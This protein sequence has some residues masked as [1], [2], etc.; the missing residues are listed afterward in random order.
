MRL[1][2]IPMFALLVASCAGGPEADP[3]TED[4]GTTEEGI[5]CSA[6]YSQCVANAWAMY[7]LRLQ[8]CHPTPYQED[9]DCE[10]RATNACDDAL[11][12][13]GSDW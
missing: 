8:V 5:W 3:S 13:C 12:A 9:F 1:L 10:R 6:C 2:A 4:V 11:N 7:R